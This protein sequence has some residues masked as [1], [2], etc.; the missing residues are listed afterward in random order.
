MTS[1]SVQTLTKKG[2]D[3][4]LAVKASIPGTVIAVGV[5]GGIKVDQSKMKS[6]ETEN[7]KA[8]TLVLGGHPPTDSRGPEGFEE[9]AKSVSEYPMPVRYEVTPVGVNIASVNPDL[10]YDFFE[11]AY[12]YV[13]YICFSII[14]ILFDSLHP[15]KVI[16]ILYCFPTFVTY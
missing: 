15:F 13:D 1:E 8:K 12:E 9:W 5:K 7:I 14:F 11:F 10:S 16:H 4:K 3:I 2:I 6:I